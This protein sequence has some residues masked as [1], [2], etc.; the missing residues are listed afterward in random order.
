[1]RPFYH[2]PG[3]LLL[4]TWFGTVAQA[5]V[6][7]LIPQPQNLTVQAGEFTLTPETVIAAGPG[8]GATAE[9]L[10]DYLRPAHVRLR[11]APPSDQAGTYVNFITSPS[12][13]SL[14]VSRSR[15]RGPAKKGLPEPI[16]TGWR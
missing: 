12:I 16:T 6:P 1:M 4:L 5:A 15:G 2:A 8:A 7:A 11:V 13:R 3:V 10:A 9:D 14:P